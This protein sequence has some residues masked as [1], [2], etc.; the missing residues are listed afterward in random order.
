MY[1]VEPVA[2]G[3]RNLGLSASLTTSVPV[4]PGVSA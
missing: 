3:W 4:S 2:N 1:A